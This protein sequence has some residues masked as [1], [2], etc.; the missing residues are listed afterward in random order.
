MALG[1]CCGEADEAEAAEALGCGSEERWGKIHAVAEGVL[2]RRVLLR[3]AEMKC[4]AC[5]EA[6]V[7]NTGQGHVVAHGVCLGS[8]GH[9]HDVDEA[10]VDT[11][12]AYRVHVLGQGYIQGCSQ[13]YNRGYTKDST[14]QAAA[15]LFASVL[16]MRV[17]PGV[18]HL[19]MVVAQL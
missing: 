3:C 11:W 9:T 12:E 18:E 15:Q 2:R 6:V 1:W 5:S 14:S 10:Q 4:A 19:V 8:S 17:A 7:G 16:H 13:D